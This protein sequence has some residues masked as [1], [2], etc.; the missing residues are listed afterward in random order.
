[1]KKREKYLLNYIDNEREI[2]EVSIQVPILKKIYM[3]SVRNI[4]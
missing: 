3:K 1:M 2:E 4:Y